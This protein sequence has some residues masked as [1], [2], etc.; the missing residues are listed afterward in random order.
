MGYRQ[1]ARIILDELSKV[2][3]INWNMEKMYLKA[4]QEGLIAVDKKRTQ[5]AATSQGSGVK[6]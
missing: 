4:I 2:M 3:N 1:E 6:K 5:E